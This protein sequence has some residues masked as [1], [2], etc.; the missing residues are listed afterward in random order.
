MWSLQRTSTLVKLLYQ[1]ILSLLVGKYATQESKESTHDAKKAT[2][3][4]Q[5][6][7]KVVDL[8]IDVPSISVQ[9]KVVLEA[10]PVRNHS[11]LRA[12]LDHVIEGLLD[13]S[14]PIDGHHPAVLPDQ[15]A[16]LHLWIQL[17]APH[18]HL[19]PIDSRDIFNWLRIV[20]IPEFLLITEH[21]N[22]LAC[23]G[24][25]ILKSGLAQVIFI[26]SISWIL[27][28]LLRYLDLV[29]QVRLRWGLSIAI[30][31]NGRIIEAL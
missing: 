17:E 23:D 18:R 20:L 4:A 14:E 31:L 26:L 16:Q 12:H 7:E 25:L 30:E 24:P 28:E 10:R 19:V 6:R 2:N 13:C 8:P 21:P 22:D 9:S 5:K 1:A 15:L 3:V 27:A 29:A 11:L